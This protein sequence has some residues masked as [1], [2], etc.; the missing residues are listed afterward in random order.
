MKVKSIFGAPAGRAPSNLS[1]MARTKVLSSRRSHTRPKKPERST[2]ADANTR[3][4]F[5]F[6]TA[7]TTRWTELIRYVPPVV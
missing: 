2:S 4:E 5:L 3:K 1:V 7:H 6:A